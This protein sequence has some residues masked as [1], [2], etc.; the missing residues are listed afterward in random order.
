MKN[1]CS[2]VRDLLPLYAENM[3]SPETAAFVEAHISSCQE[4]LSV[5]DEIKSAPVPAPMADAAPL[6]A[7]GRKITR[8]RIF[9]ALCAAFI[10]A[11]AA[12]ALF[13]A[14]NAPR[15]YPY[16]EYLFTLHEES[17]GSVELVFGPGVTYNSSEHY[18]YEEGGREFLV[19][20]VQAGYS[21]ADRLRP[22]GVYGSTLRLFPREDMPM[23]VFYTP[24]DD[25]DNVCIYG[26]E[27]V[28]YGVRTLPRLTLGFYFIIALVLAAVFTVCACVFRKARHVFFVLL[29]FPGSYILSHLAVMGLRMS[30]YDIER[31]FIS[32]LLVGFFVFCAVQCAFFALRLRRKSREIWSRNDL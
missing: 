12:F 22:S 6:R 30:T 11:A 20:D 15:Y 18:V 16:S 13:I 10:A 2:V 4:C 32:I 7:L 24:N 3:V 21:I 27:Y 17:D 23:V 29:A 5:L 19:Y 14:M 1:E 26:E 8:A 31:E 9:A 28:N 25:S